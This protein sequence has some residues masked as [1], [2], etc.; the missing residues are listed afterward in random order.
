[1]RLS[2]WLQRREQQNGAEEGLENKDWRRDVL[3]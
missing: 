2:G 3:E 1:M